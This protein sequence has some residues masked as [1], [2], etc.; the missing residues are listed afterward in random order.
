VWQIGRAFG[1]A[2]GTDAAVTTGLTVAAVACLV[3]ASLLAVGPGR[4]SARLELALGLSLVC[5][6]AS[7]SLFG[8]LRAGLPLFRGLRSPGHFFDL[9][10]FSFYGVFGVAVVAWAHALP[11]GNRR[12]AAAVI[13]AAL[14]AWD[15]AP[16]RAA[17]GQGIPLEAVRRAERRSPRCRTTAARSAS[18]QSVV[19]PAERDARRDGCARRPR[20]DV[21]R[22]VGG[23]HW[24]AFM[25]AAMTWT[26]PDLDDTE[27]KRARPVGDALARIGRLAYAID[28]KPPLPRFAPPWQGVLRSEYFALWRQPDVGPMAAGYRAYVT[29]SADERWEH[30]EAVAAAYRRDLLAVPATEPRP[31]AIEPSA[32][33]EPVA[34]GPPVPVAYRRPVPERIVLELDA[35]P[36]P[37]LVFVSEAYHPWWVA[38][39]DGR[40]ARVVRAQMAFMAVGVGPGRHT[41]ELRMRRPA[42]VA[43]AD[44]LT[45]AAWVAV[46]LG[47]GWWV[48]RA[49]LVTPRASR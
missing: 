49:A 44:W 12:T 19:L 40:A 13:L 15:F 35:G 34:S 27:R 17:F 32:G 28:E 23:K 2:D 9:A 29:V 46:A 48:A 43:A 47:A 26:V 22:L 1:W 4:A 33:A 3:W 25:E 20:L 31:D 45:R 21:A 8:L 11:A 18:R 39:A 14:L 41:V 36:Q 10:P 24:R 42:A 16:S 30:A 37:A 5:F 7:H 6:A 38:A